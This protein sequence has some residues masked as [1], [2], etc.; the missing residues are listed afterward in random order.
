MA[1]PFDIL[2]SDSTA[3]MKWMVGTPEISDMV[4]SFQSDQI[5]EDVL[6]YQ[7][8]DRNSFEKKIRKDVL[9]KLGNLF[10]NKENQLVQIINKSMSEQCV[11]SVL[12]ARKIGCDQYNTFLQKYMEKSKIITYLCSEKRT[13]YVQERTD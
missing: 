2:L 5:C 9:N 7:H 8:E 13:I 6:Q 3:L 10:D 1:A 11:E 12:Q 4:Q